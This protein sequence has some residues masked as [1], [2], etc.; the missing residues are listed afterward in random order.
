MRTPGALLDPLA[1]TTYDEEHSET[2]E[3]WFTLGPSRDRQL[4]AVAHAFVVT[5][6]HQRQRAAEFR[7]PR[8]APRG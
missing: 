4:V 8:C 5:G 3:R 2:E 6:P 7:S 1:L